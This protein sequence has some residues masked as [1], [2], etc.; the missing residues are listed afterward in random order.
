MS[1]RGGTTS[2]LRGLMG[3]FRSRA[4]GIVIAL[5]RAFARR[6]AQRAQAATEVGDLAARMAQTLIKIEDDAFADARCCPICHAA[7]GAPGEGDSLTHAPHCTLDAVLNAYGGRRQPS[8]A[9]EPT[10]SKNERTTP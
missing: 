8:Q 1:K 10:P 9:E 5:S 2:A 4:T 6:E 7:P 3:P